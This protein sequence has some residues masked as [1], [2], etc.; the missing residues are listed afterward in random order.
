M[1]WRVSLSSQLLWS[2]LQSLLQL[3]SPFVIN[4]L[5]TVRSAENDICTLLSHTV[6]CLIT[7][8]YKAVLIVLS[9]FDQECVQ[10]CTESQFACEIV[11][12][13]SNKAFVPNFQLTSYSNWSPVHYIYVILLC[14]A[15]CLLRSTTEQINIQAEGVSWKIP[16]TPRVAADQK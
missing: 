1:V 4:N 13:I 9:E 12:W 5:D 15:L 11:A 2:F 8:V 6:N 10:D 7:P 16:G 3:S 14:L